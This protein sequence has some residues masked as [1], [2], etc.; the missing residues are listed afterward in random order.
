M[1]LGFQEE[2]RYETVNSEIY[3]R[4]SLQKL[5]V[6]SYNIKHV[7]MHSSTKT[8]NKR[9]AS[10]TKNYIRYKIQDEDFT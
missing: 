6:G 7:F 4:Q 1:A 5:F 10:H 9:R 3:M 8:Q 2:E